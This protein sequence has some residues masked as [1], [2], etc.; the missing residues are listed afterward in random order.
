[1]MTR[2]QSIDRCREPGCRCDDRTG[3]IL[4]DGTSYEAAVEAAERLARYNEPE[5]IELDE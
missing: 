1:M 2:Y 5:I 4:Y 3:V